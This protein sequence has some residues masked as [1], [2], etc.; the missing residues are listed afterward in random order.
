M[1]SLLHEA[2][3]RD[4]EFGVGTQLVPDVVGIEGGARWEKEIDSLL[5]SLFLRP[6]LFGNCL[7]IPSASASAICSA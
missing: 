1:T 3:R 2:L 4:A 6:Y 7:L 5:P